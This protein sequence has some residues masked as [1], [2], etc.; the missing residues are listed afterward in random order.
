MNKKNKKNQQTN[1]IIELFISLPSSVFF[2]HSLFASFI[3]LT[4]IVEQCSKNSCGWCA[5]ARSHGSKCV[6]NRSS[7]C[8]D[9]HTV[10]GFLSFILC[11]LLSQSHRLTPP[12]MRTWRVEIYTQNVSKNRTNKCSFM[13]TEQWHDIPIFD[14]NVWAMH[15]IATRLNWC[16]NWKEKVWQFQMF[17]ISLRLVFFSFFKRLFLQSNFFL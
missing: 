5:S 13:C 9:D 3:W 1:K 14:R 17:S 2:F 15:V 16:E 11:W 8:V 4:N 7:V 6:P 10:V 12:P